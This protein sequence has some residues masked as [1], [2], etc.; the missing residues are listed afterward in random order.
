MMAAPERVALF[1]QATLTIKKPGI[2]YN[3]PSYE[4]PD[5]TNPRDA[6]RQLDDC[7]RQLALELRNVKLSVTVRADRAR[8][9]T[10]DFSILRGRFES[11]R[12]CMAQSYEAQAQAATSADEARRLLDQ[13]EIL[14]GQRRA[15]LPMHLRPHPAPR[16]APIDGIYAGRCLPLADPRSA[17]KGFC[18][19]CGHWLPRLLGYQDGVAV[20]VLQLHRAKPH[21]Y[22]KAPPMKL[23]DVPLCRTVARDWSLIEAR[24]LTPKTARAPLEIPALMDRLAWMECHLAN[25]PAEFGGPMLDQLPAL[26]AVYEQRRGVFQ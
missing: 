24:P 6:E 17:D 20:W 7:I 8:S 5:P 21:R 4:F 25:V 16:P 15:D 22:S 9:F 10:A 11:V 26:Q 14:D 3:F 2:E 18:H 23:Q 1:L 13:A 19:G 12:R